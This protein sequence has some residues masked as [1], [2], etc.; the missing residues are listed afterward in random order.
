M[1]QDDLDRMLSREEAI[2]PSSGFV[3]SVM[4]AVR[5]EAST[6]PPIAFPWKWALPGLA[7]WTTLL[8]WFV[9]AVFAQPARGAV[10]P[11]VALPPMLIRI[12]EGAESIGVGWVALALLMSFASVKLSLCLIGGKT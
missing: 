3:S 8:V 12:L 1:R 4:D 9:I 10:A 2:V 5:W 11:S 6:P 7:A